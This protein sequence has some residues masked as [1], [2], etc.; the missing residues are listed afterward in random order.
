MN[1]CKEPRLSYLEIKT[2]IDDE[3][4]ASE[5]SNMDIHIQKDDIKLDECLFHHVTFQK[6]HFCQCDFMDVIFEN[7]DCSGMDFSNSL[8]HRVLFKNCRM[9]GCDFID[10]DLSDVQLI[11]NQMSL[12]NFSGSR[13]KNSKIIQSNL[14]ESRFVD[15]KIQDSEIDEC[16]FTQ[17]EFIHTPLKDLDFSTS[18]LNGITLTSD[19]IPGIMVNAFQ[20]IELSKLLGIVIKE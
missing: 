17:A 7:C 8:F 4:I 3:W 19:C 1:K 13:I 10:T 14:C 2:K 6:S 15:T 20:A 12:C 11:G 16:C 9:I 18:D 5:Y